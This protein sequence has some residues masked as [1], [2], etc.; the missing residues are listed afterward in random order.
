MQDGESIYVVPEEA[1][2][3]APPSYAVAQADQAPAYYETF[4]HA[5]SAGLDG[6]VLV[7]GMREQHCCLNHGVIDC[8][9]S[10][11]F[12]FHIRMDHVDIFIF[13]ICGIFVYI[14]SSYVR[15]SLLATSHFANLISEHTQRGM[16][17][18]LASE[19]PLSNTPFSSDNAQRKLKKVYTTTPKLVFGTPYLIPITTTTPLL[20]C[21]PSRKAISPLIRLNGSPFSS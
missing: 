11:G 8:I 14:P 7:D 9:F 21:P 10:N 2:K 1:Q 4:V 20:S 18:V 6:E 3:E 15:L 19:S 12:Y 13:P 5:P 16:A 17:L